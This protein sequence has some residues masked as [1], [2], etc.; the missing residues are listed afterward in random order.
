MKMAPAKVIILFSNLLEDTLCPESR[1]NAC[2]G[3]ADKP[4]R[5]TERD[6]PIL[7]SNGL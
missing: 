3:A 6:R 4:G 7:L 2:E 1:P 5:D